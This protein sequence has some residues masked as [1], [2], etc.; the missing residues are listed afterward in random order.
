MFYDAKAQKTSGKL[1]LYCYIHFDHVG[2][3]LAKIRVMNIG[4]DRQRVG[5]IQK[6]KIKGHL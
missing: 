4:V 2:K 3:S 6:A 5:K 1:F